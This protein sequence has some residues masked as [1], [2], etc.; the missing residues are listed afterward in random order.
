VKYFAQHQLDG[1]RAACAALRHSSPQLAGV[2][3]TVDGAAAAIQK[4]QALSF[5]G[6]A[7]CAFNDESRRRHPRR[8]PPVRSRRYR[9]SCRH[10]V[11]TTSPPPPSLPQ[12][13]PPSPTT[14]PPPHKKSSTPSCA[15]CEGRP[16]P[17]NRHGRAGHHAGIRLS[18]SSLFA[19]LLAASLVWRKAATARLHA[20]PLPCEPGSGRGGRHVPTVGSKRPSALVRPLAVL[21]VW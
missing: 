18:P 17:S 19:P 7:I 10:S 5:A 12:R 2:P 13:S 20:P 9:K 1:V 21:L 15:N 16:Q 8:R 14:S 4:W 3:L 6:T 11:S